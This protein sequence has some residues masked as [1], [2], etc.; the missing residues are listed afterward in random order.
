MLVPGVQQSESVLYIYPLF[1]RFY[2]HIDHYRVLGRVPCAMGGFLLF[3]YSM[4]SSV[5]ISIP[6]S[7][8][9]CPSPYSLPL[10]AFLPGS[11]SW[12]SASV[13]LLFKWDETEVRELIR[14]ASKVT[15]RLLWGPRCKE[16]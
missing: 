15:Q 10:P 9:S 4:Y 8:L 5:S 2:S 11:Q 7:S 13:T 12:F 16:E 1:F 14:K 6:I 3:I